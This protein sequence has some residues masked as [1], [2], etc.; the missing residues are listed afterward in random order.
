M[1]EIAE[2]MYWEEVYEA[3]EYASNLNTIEKNDAYKFQYMLH[4]TTKNA[5][6]SWRDMPIPFPDRDWKPPKKREAPLPM[7][8][9]AKKS[10]STMTPERRERAEY[11]KRRL[12]EG[13]QKAEDELQ[14][15]YQGN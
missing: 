14:K 5:M 15:Y 4:A 11:I 1:S 13:R 3:Y 12:A 2:N 8:F 9:H 7:Q 6:N 10:T